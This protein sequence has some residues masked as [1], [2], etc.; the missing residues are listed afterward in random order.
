MANDI[1]MSEMRRSEGAF[2]TT[3]MHKEQMPVS[4]I[5][6]NSF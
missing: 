5:D 2:G 3:M 1:P 4:K 6:S